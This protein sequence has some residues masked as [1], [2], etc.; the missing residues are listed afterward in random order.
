MLDLIKKQKRL[1]IK[2][3]QLKNLL[4]KLL[5]GLV[6]ATVIACSS[7]NRPSSTAYSST[8]QVIKEPAPIVIV[9]DKKSKNYKL[10]YGNDRAVEAAFNAYAKTGKADNI[11][12]KGFTK[13]AYSSMQQ[14][15]INCMP[16][17]QTVITLEAGEKFTSITSGDPSNLSYLV[18]VSGASTGVE[19]QQVL[20]KPASPKMSTN[21]IITTDKRIYNILIVVGGPKDK[22]T[23]NVSFWYPDDMLN[24]VN[25]NIEKQ[26]DITVNAEKTPQLN[27]ADANFN[28]KIT[29]DDD[30]SWTP[31]R[32][33]DDGKRT[34]IEFPNG[35]DSKNLPTVLIQS[36]SGNLV[37]YNVSY[38]SPYYVIQ[39][40]FSRAKL[41]AGVG[42]N[43]VS[44]DV[45][46]K[47]F[48][49]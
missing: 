4:N 18:A 19:T 49:R 40:V 11:I 44:V 20:V 36:D 26:N 3:F 31:V 45:Y 34:W 38:Y 2:E 24:K 10:V 46:N 43:Q 39:G 7:T 21:L 14:P 5:L 9:D 16:F 27:L 47:N 22:I 30:P 33:F 17:Q 35:V 32:A 42:G 23:R 48:K 6:A 8:T 13:F 37:K 25:D 29:T 12:T 28:Y 1:L 41:V 15:I